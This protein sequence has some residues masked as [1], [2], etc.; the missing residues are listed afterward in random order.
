[1]KKLIYMAI[2]FTLTACVAKRQ[3][4]TLPETVSCNPTFQMLWAS[5]TEETKNLR[6]LDSY[7]PSDEFVANY[8]LSEQDGK[9]IVSGFLQTN[10]QFSQTD[11]EKLGGSLVSYNNGL[12]T[13]RI[14]V[15]NLAKMVYLQGITRIEASNKVQLKL[16]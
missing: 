4:V 8:N 13:F 2:A 6:S 7:T 16:R 5:F 3:I 12:Y 9:Y 1:M 14:P 15:N 11:F 10:E